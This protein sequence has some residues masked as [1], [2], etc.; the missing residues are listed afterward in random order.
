MGVHLPHGKAPLGV[1][2]LDLVPNQ[3]LEL[4]H[5]EVAL[6]FNAPIECHWL[7]VRPEPCVQLPVRPCNFTPPLSKG[8]STFLTSSQFEVTIGRCVKKCQSSA[9]HLPVHFS[10][11]PGLLKGTDLSQCRCMQIQIQSLA[12]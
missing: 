12:D 5:Y 10:R 4:A 2:Q 11:I 7:R 1:E 6:L 8:F 9:L 3:L